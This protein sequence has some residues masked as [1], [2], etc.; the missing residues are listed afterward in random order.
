MSSALAIA[1]VT[2]VIRDLLNN[3]FIKNG[4]TDV[5]GQG[6]DVTA[7]APDLIQTQGNDARPLLNIFLHQITFNPAWRNVDLPSVDARGSR[8]ANPPL[9]VDLH[10]LITAYGTRDVQAEVLLGY[11]MQLLHET[12]VFAREAIRVALAPPVADIATLPPIYQK[13]RTAALAEQIELLKITPAGWQGEEMSRLW[14]A[15]Q[16][17]YRPSVPYQVSVVLIDSEQPARAPLPV[18]TRGQRDPITGVEQGVAVTTDLSSPFP[19][20]T[21]ITLP[22]KQVVARLGETVEVKGARLDGTNRAALLTHPRLHFTR[23][24]PARPGNA[25]D[26]LS[27]VVPDDPVN[28]PAGTYLLSVSLLRPG[29]TQAREAGPLLLPIAPSITSALPM[30]VPRDA[31]GIAHVMLSFEPQ[32]RPGQRIS[33]LLGTRDIPGEVTTQT[34]NLTFDVAQARPGEYYAR[35]RVDGVESIVVDR[36]A[37]PPRFL[38]LRIN[39]V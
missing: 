10:Y 13:L 5:M 6:V 35:L 27:F 7:L 8:V 12:P 37:T 1:G 38:N 4:V 21:G 3:G 33:L 9:A 31:Q 11:A 2:A 23:T 29:E 18:L 20:I 39:V 25:A 30:N 36:A 28:L 17:H 32:V 14:T 19:D 22:N 24:V 34:D 16:T 26:S 15:A